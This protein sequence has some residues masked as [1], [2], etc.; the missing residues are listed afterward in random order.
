MHRVGMTPLHAILAELETTDTQHFVTDSF[1]TFDDD[2][3]KD[4]SR[5]DRPKPVRRELE[6][7]RFEQP[8]DE[9]ASSEKAWDDEFLDGVILASDLPDDASP[10]GELPFDP[11]TGATHGNDGSEDDVDVYGFETDNNPQLGLRGIPERIG[12][13][14]IERMIGSGGMGRVYLAKHQTMQRTVAIKTLP[15]EQSAQRWAVERFYEEVRAAA[16]LL[17]PNIA[18][19]FDAGHSNGV[20]FLAMEYINGSTLTSLVAEHGPMSIADAVSAVRGAAR[21]LAHAH[22]AGVVHRDVKPSNLMRASDGT[23]KVVDLGLALFAA[24]Q[25]I[26]QNRREGNAKTSGRLVGTIAFMSPEQL[27]NPDTVDSRSD[28]YSLGATLYFL[29]TGRPPYSGEFLD[30]IRG[31]R[32]DPV[33]ELFSLRPDVDLRLEHVF[34]RMMA[35]RPQERYA[36]LV[37][38]L[39][40]LSSHDTGDSSVAWISALS[41]PSFISDTTTHRGGSTSGEM[42]KVMGIDF[43]MFYAT[44]AM[45][46]PA[47]NVE[48]LMPPDHSAAQTRLAIADGSPLLFGDAA[49]AK[50]EHQPGS[51]LHCVPLYVGQSKVD[52]L[53]HGKNCPAEVLLA[54][55]I[56]KL[57]EQ[58]WSQRAL[59]HA[60]A[61]TVPS[62]YD[63]FHRQALIQAATIA[64]VRSVRLVDRSLA[65]LQAW[66]S[67]QAALQANSSEAPQ[68][69]LKE[70]TERPHI[71]VSITGM[72]TEVVICRYRGSRIQ[73]L[74]AVGQWHYGTLQWQQKLIDMVAEECLKQHRFDPRQ[75]LQTATAL[76]LACERAL[77]KFLLLE[78]VNIA[79]QRGTRPIAIS[80]SR[81]D[82]LDACDGFVTELLQMID[83]AL[84]AADIDPRRISHCFLVGILTRMAATRRRI[85]KKFAADVDI[86]LSER[87]DIARG[88]AICVAGEL[89]GRGD[90]PLPPQS[91]TSHDFGLLVVDSKNR[92]R[93]RPII[94]RGTAIPARTNR[95]IATGAATSQVLTVV[96][97]STWRETSWRSLGRHELAVEPNEA[98]VEVTFEVNVDGRLIVRRR[99]PNS[100]STGTLPALPTPTLTTEEVQEWTEWVREWMPSA[101]RRAT[102]A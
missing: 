27:E 19:A 64:G 13:Y 10:T 86:T 54:L 51:V 21:G 42:P 49:A 74:A 94:P 22:A 41:T 15:P 71:V 17:H 24:P 72:A 44:C 92:R 90:I 60:I 56:R 55:Q 83:N 2:P 89:P 30:Q 79:F 95:R 96:E 58:C 45:A 29:L 40:D 99:D 98:Y 16:R 81:T 63:Q 14:V 59:P 6:P 25:Q 53:I 37:E 38:V 7:T 87:S 73:Q 62:T 80:V 39:A 93:I 101:K 36:S 76:Q 35:K 61:L 84:E 70:R 18:T 26:I 78:K 1:S 8:D 85:E 34:R 28:I 75:N 97:S 9:A 102:Q 5:P 43:G 88:A 100:G 31:I 91:A 23:V 4:H 66:R 82:W 47:G 11:P 57:I 46:E 65:V 12:D 69:S 3:R 52:H 48:V 32:H 67:D 50:R 20:H 77:P 33:P 68:A